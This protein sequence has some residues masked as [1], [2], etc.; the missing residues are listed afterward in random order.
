VYREHA[1]N[2]RVHLF[3][4]LKWR[5]LVNRFP[6]DNATLKL[7]HH[8]VGRRLAHRKD[9][10]CVFGTRGQGQRSILVMKRFLAKGYC[11]R[12]RCGHYKWTLQQDSA[13]SPQK[14]CE[15][16]IHRAEHDIVTTR[17]PRSESGGLYAV[18]EC[19]WRWFTTA[20]VSNL[21]KNSEVQLVAA[22]QQLPQAFR[23]QSISE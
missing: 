18:G 23:E 5:H 6:L 9:K 17:Q 10:R 12:A 13:P 21:C 15:N 16:V 1:Y 20:E 8:V 22:W 7:Q 3:Y 11:I 2:I 4:Y 14:Q 19:F